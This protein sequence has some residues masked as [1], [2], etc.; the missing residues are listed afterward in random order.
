[1]R[2]G[3][4][5]IVLLVVIALCASF[6]GCSKNSEGEPHE[7]ETTKA[8]SSTLEKDNANKI[9]EKEVQKLLDEGILG[10]GDEYYTVKVDA[11][12]SWYLAWEQIVHTVTGEDYCF[13]NNPKAEREG[14]FWAAVSQIPRGTHPDDFSG[15]LKVPQTCSEA[16]EWAESVEKALDKNQWDG[17]SITLA[18]T[19]EQNPEYDY[20][21]EGG[22]KDE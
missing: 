8:E 5:I 10:K 22:G 13:T 9:S 21:K 6:C 20:R 2:L 18:K 14:C 16:K 17:W 19:L 4:G 15:Q 1:M 12:E 11:G 7:L 3:K